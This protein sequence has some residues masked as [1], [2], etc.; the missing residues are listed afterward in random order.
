MSDSKKEWVVIFLIYADLRA[1]Q[2]DDGRK[3]IEREL[4]S[5]FSDIRSCE[6]NEQSRIYI[7]Y[8]IVRKYKAKEN[9]ITLLM[10]A[11][12][13]SKIKERKN[14]IIK[15][16]KFDTSEIVRKPDELSK[17]F[18]LIDKEFNAKKR[19]LITWDHG[20]SFGIF[21]DESE[22]ITS[23]GKRLFYF[24]SNPPY[25]RP[26]DKTVPFTDRDK[27]IDLL[28]SENLAVAIR[29]GFGHNGVDV[30]VMM[31]CLMQNTHT[32]FALRHDVHYLVAPI[33]GIDEPGYNYPAIINSIMYQSKISAISIARLAVSSIA[34][35]DKGNEL[36]ADTI[37]SFGI[38]TVNLKYYVLYIELL[39]QVASFLL[40]IMNNDL[41]Q[42]IK[43][44]RNNC[45]RYDDTGPYHSI[46]VHTWLF[47]LYLQLKDKDPHNV[48]V[49]GY[50]NCFKALRK[51]IIK[52]KFV[53]V[54]VYDERFP[55]SLS[56]NKKPSG[57]SI[58]YP[59]NNRGLSANNYFETFVQPSAPQRCIFF[60][61]TSW[62]NYLQEIVPIKDS[63]SPY[64]FFEI[65]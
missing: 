45:Y 7:V 36:F 30:L 34:D 46:D 48:R 43:S 28:S 14:R 23:E 35:N 26:W 11:Q 33:G 6:L 54:N 2:N 21:K 25:E 31:N 3:K 41:H 19:L 56:E 44:S 63:T 15:K 49:L 5:L 10:Q 42:A 47:K 4:K 65:H 58:F 9:D 20:A 1:R 38:F 37:K 51:M 16:R 32:A 61:Q 55:G 12:K 59:L 64:A 53:G 60:K 40:E 52:E 62:Y 29:K 13:G 8:N 50:Y 24:Y 18:Q 17:I 22:T 27:V 57:F 39:D